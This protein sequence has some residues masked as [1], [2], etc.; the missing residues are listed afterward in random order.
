MDTLDSSLAF[1]IAAGSANVLGGLMVVSRREPWHPRI[2]HGFVAIGAGFM[3]AAA[4][5]RMEPEAA[6]LTR[7]APLLLLGGYLVV[8]LFEHTIAAHFHFGEET[9]PH[10]L[11]RSSVWASALIGL[12]VHSLF[13][14]ISIASGFLVSPALGFLVFTAII[15]HKAPE[16]FAIASVMIAAGVSRSGA[17]ASTLAVGAASVVGVLT[18]QAFAG[19]VGAALALSTG[20]TLYVA[21]SDLI[22]EVNKEEGALMAVLVFAGVALFYVSEEILSALGL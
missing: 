6:R 14:G 18:T 16:G 1:G 19:Y 5:L 2:L 22:P 20:V 8:H 15:L 13:D 9:H 17:L 11:R 4:L 12:A 7:S 21:A 3:L 10:L